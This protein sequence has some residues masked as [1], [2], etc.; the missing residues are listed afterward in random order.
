MDVKVNKSGL[1]IYDFDYETY[2]IGDY[3]QSIAARQYF[4]SINQ[5]VNRETLNSY[6]GPPIKV[7]MNGWFLH[8]IENW[9]PSDNIFPLFI[10]FHLNF[11][12]IKILDKI[13][14]IQYFKKY[15]P[16][17]CRDYYTLELLKS[18]GIRAYF[19]GC[20]TLTLGKSYNN[21]VD[22]G[23]ILFVDILPKILSITRSKN[24]VKQFYKDRKL[25]KILE[26][27]YTHW[28]NRK[29]VLRR[30]LII[31]SIFEK[32]ILKYKREIF[33]DFYDNDSHDNR[34]NKAENLLS[35]YSKARI[36][37]TSKI[38]CALPCLAMGTP[39]V[40][41]KGP[42]LNN[43]I[44]ACR[45]EGV[46]E[47]LNVIEVDSSNNISINYAEKFSKIDLNFKITNREDISY[48]VKKFNDIINEYL[49]K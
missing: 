7:I 40:F 42:D 28:K 35:L 19:S 13:Q 46:L 22:N 16:I 15:E 26:L 20:L 10:S 1:L 49:R 32:D 36:V 38:H 3:I 29:K 44:D 24:A 30:N 14:N 25:I 6:D 18:K 43:E 27:I 9:P 12:A 21:E 45:L 48:F 4:Q 33:H 41:I 31:N 34:F 39:V 5:F 17:G 23:E 2:N 8:N 37:F 11:S 47:F